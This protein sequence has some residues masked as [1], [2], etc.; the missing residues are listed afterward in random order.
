MLLPLVAIQA[1]SLQ[2]PRTNPKG[3]ISLDSVTD[4]F[5]SRQKAAL[6]SVGLSRESALRV[7]GAL[8]E[9]QKEKAVF[10]D[11]LKA[12]SSAVERSANVLEVDF[13]YA[14]VGESAKNIVLG[15]ESLNEALSAIQAPL[16]LDRPEIGAEIRD[17]MRQRGVLTGQDILR[18]HFLRGMRPKR[19]SRRCPARRD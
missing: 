7:Q 19:T 8:I 2:S 11:A 3:L 18:D 6:S 10:L 13:K 15:I 4:L 9:L 14:D 1:Q 12:Y 5:T 17:Y 16:D